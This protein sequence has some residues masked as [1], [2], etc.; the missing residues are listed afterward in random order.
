LLRSYKGDEE[1]KANTDQEIKDKLKKSGMGLVPD[2]VVN[3]KKPS[4]P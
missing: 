2:Y 1:E 4:K 3:A